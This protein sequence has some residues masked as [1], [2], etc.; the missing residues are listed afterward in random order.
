MKKYIQNDIEIE[1]N[2]LE[3]QRDGDFDTLA[4]GGAGVDEVDYSIATTYEAEEQKKVPKIFSYLIFFLSLI[5]A[6]CGGL[7]VKE[8][9]LTP[10]QV[11]QTSMFDTLSDG[12]R[13]YINQLTKGQQF[14]IVVIYEPLV[15]QNWLIK[16]IIATGGQEVEIADGILY[17]T[18]NG[19]TTAYDEQYV[20]GSNITQEKVYIP[21]GYIYVLGDNRSVS[22]DSADYGVILWERVV[23][24]AIFVDSEDAVAIDSYPA[25]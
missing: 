14:D 20:N 9:V 5:I 16:R 21:E 25:T 24:K 3:S 12:D 18:E 13:L 15:S 10:V 7:I 23:G 19:I 8:Y 11:A 17:I 4:A 22:I 2:A 6:F 1:K